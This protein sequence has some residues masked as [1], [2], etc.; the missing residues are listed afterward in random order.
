M[1]DFYAMLFNFLASLETFLDEVFL[2][3]VPFDA[4]TLKAFS[5]LAKATSATALSPESTA[6]LNF[7]RTVFNSDFLALLIAVFLEITL[8]LFSADL[9][10]AII[11]TS[12]CLVNKTIL[13]LFKTKINIKLL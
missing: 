11:F 3:S 10:L 2:C 1:T 13:S 5:A 9:I 4:V 8:I 7:L 12:L 6:A